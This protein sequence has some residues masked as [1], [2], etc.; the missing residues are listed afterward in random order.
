MPPFIRPEQ[1]KNGR[2]PP[3]RRLQHRVVAGALPQADWCRA[4][5]NSACTTVARYALGR[6]K[7]LEYLPNFAQVLQQGRKSTNILV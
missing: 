1:A 4:E 3:K 7:L 6:I 5:R 2:A